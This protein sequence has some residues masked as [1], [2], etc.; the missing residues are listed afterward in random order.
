MLLSRE[1]AFSLRLRLLFSWFGFT[2]RHGHLFRFNASD[3][4]IQF[5]SPLN[6]DR[7]LEQNLPLASCRGPELH[8][9]ALKAA[10]EL[11]VNMYLVFCLN[12][13]AEELAGYLHVPSGADIPSAHF[14]FDIDAAPLSIDV[15]FASAFN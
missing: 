7:L 13:A 1:E 11:A 2:F 4:A 12:L 15:P 5:R 9:V 3:F 10:C 8:L 6:A 14:A